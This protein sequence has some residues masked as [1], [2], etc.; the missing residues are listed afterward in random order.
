MITRDKS[1]SA[2]FHNEWKHLSEPYNQDFE[3]LRE[4]Y[5]NR[6]AKIIEEGIVE[7]EFHHV[8]SRFTVRTLLS[9]LNWIHN[10]YQPNG[11]MT[12]EEIGEELSAFFI[13]GLKN[14]T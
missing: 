5:T 7:G 11:K 14:I 4:D 1:A 12:P 3:S 2:V 9:S 13:R 8:N 6:F 10:W